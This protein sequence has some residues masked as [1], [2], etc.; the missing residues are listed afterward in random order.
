MAA[1]AN[2]V[3]K[4]AINKSLSSIIYGVELPKSP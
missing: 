3:D 4:K 1:N 2:V